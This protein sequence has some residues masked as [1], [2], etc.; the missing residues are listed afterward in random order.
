MPLWPSI[1][2]SK[3]E[4][5]VLIKFLDQLHLEEL[6][7]IMNLVLLID[8]WHVREI[9]VKI[10]VFWHRDAYN[11]MVMSIKANAFSVLLV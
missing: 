1:M 9:N 10:L 11:F 2:E 6:L 4:K 5:K 8:I 3:K 7:N